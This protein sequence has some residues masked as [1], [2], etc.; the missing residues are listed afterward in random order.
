MIV[1]AKVEQFMT[2]VLERS[3]PGVIDWIFNAHTYRM[4]IQFTTP[5][6]RVVD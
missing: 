5:S 2:V 4:Q 6:H 3:R 1:Q